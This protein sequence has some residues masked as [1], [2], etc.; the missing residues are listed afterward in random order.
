MHRGRLVIKGDVS[1]LLSGRTHMR[2]EDFF[3]DVIGDDLAIG[4]Q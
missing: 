1:E 3:M 2:L 4:K